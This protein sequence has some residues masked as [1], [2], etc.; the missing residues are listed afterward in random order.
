M[1]ATHTGRTRR[2]RQRRLPRPDTTGAIILALVVIGALKTWPVQVGIA[3]GLAAAALM[4]RAIRPRRLAALWTFL[5]QAAARRRTLPAG[6]VH[7]SDFQRMDHREFEYAIAELARQH[8]TVHSAHRVGG[9]NDRGADVIATLHTGHRIL[10]QC[11]KYRPGNNVG[12]DT[13]QTINGVYRDIHHCHHA[14]IVTTAAFTRDAHHT[15]ALLP[16]PIR[17]ID[18]PALEAWANNGHAPW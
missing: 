5:D 14:V 7:L 2:R 12:S 10:I 8:P 15:N 16:T 18:G 9:A 11:K 6:Y 13:I 17:L 1:T 4:L 3:L